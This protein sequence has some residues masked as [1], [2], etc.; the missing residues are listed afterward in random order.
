MDNKYLQL[1]NVGKTYTGGYRSLAYV[2]FAMDRGEV[3]VI[4]GGH[5][6]GKTTLLSLI[7]GLENLSSG[8]IIMQGNDISS[9]AIADREVGLLLADLPYF[10]S[11]DVLYNLTYPLRIRKV[12]LPDINNKL[13][14]I[15]AISKIKNYL[16]KLG[17]NLTRYEKT[18]C[19]LAR[20]AMCDRK[21]YLIDDIFAEL[22]SQE[23][24]VVIN[25]IK[26]LF[27]NKTVVIVTSSLDTAKAIKP[28]NIG[29]LCYNTMSDYGKF[30]KLNSMINTA[31]SAKFLLDNAAIEVPC[32]INNDGTIT[33]FGQVLSY[34]RKLTSHVFVDGIIIVPQDDILVAKNGRFSG[35]V[36]KF[37]DDNITIKVRK[38]EYILLCKDTGVMQVGDQV[39][40]DFDVSRY[41]MYDFGSE[42]KISI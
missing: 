38:D 37:T 19:T 30:D 27:A 33:V 36:V 41:A 31:A 22:N 10:N 15:I 3:T 21:L 4:V 20:L 42:R 7:S 25:L 24:E 14:E 40:F 9:M 16:T 11:R 17:K 13:D 12:S 8:R 1:I 2:S 23:S 34:E 5:V 6:S 39:N 32:D 18:L 26:K 28:D 35:E 29:I